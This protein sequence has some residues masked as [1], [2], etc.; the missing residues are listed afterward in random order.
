LAEEEANVATNLDDQP[1]ILVDEETGEALHYEDNLDSSM[2]AI[3]SGFDALRRGLMSM[4]MAIKTSYQSSS[5]A[6][7]ELLKQ[8]RAALLQVIQA[9]SRHLLKLAS[10]DCIDG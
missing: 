4:D 1:L 2:S 7:V 3:T 5:P 10:A 9:H 6:G 8:R